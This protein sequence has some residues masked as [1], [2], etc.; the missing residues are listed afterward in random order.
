VVGNDKN[1]FKVGCIQRKTWCKGPY[2]GVD[3]YSP[4]LIVNSVVSY[5]PPLQREW[6]GV[7]KLAVVELFCICLYFQNRFFYVNTRTEKGEGRGES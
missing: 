7:A 5:P 3:Y 1:E 2:A 6:G 4:Y